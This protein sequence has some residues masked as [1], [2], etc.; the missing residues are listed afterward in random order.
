MS[1]GQPGDPVLGRR[2]KSAHDDDPFAGEDELWADEDAL[3]PHW[4]EPSPLLWRGLV[5]GLLLSLGGWLTLA[6]LAL[7][8]YLLLR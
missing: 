1:S 2:D 8:L 6:A 4:E 5:I 7:A 3:T